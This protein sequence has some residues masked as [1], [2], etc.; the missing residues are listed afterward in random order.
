MARRIYLFLLVCFC[1]SHALAADTLYQGGDSL[2]STN[3]LVSKNGLF[4][5]GFTILGSAE[6]N[7]SYLEIWYN[8]DTSHP[9]WLANRN[10]STV[11]NSGVLP[12]EQV[13][14]N[15]LMKSQSPPSGEVTRA[16][17]GVDKKE[18][19]SGKEE[20]EHGE[21]EG[22][23][24]FMACGVPFERRKGRDNRRKT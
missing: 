4:T 10:K 3:T 21:D 15:M 13:Q 7:A 16:E 11:E 12:L 14:R 2:N 9:F 18:L 24:K 8:N 22:R 17:H 19:V 1:A 5:L 6:S 20:E 23:G